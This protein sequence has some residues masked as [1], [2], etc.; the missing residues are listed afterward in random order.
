M[1]PAEMRR[2]RAFK[3]VVVRDVLIC[4][5]CKMPQASL[6][7]CHV[8]NGQTY[9][10]RCHAIFLAEEAKLEGM[11]GRRTYGVCAQCC[12]RGSVWASIRDGDGGC[13]CKVCWLMKWVERNDSTAAQ[14]EIFA[15]KGPCAAALMTPAPSPQGGLNPDGLDSNGV[16]TA[17]NLM[18]T[19]L[20]WQ[21]G[22][23]MGLSE[24]VGTGNKRKAVTEVSHAKRVC[25][26]DTAMECL[27]RLDVVANFPDAVMHAT[28]GD[29]LQEAGR[30]W[31][32]KGGIPWAF[33]EKKLVFGY[34][35]KKCNQN[36]DANEGAKWQ[37]AQRQHTCC[38]FQLLGKVCS[39]RKC[40]FKYHFHQ[41]FRKLIDTESALETHILPDYK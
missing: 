35:G 20:A 12:R 21:H 18:A 17:L 36:G 31:V 2:N 24:T 4:F 10:Q 40:F 26:D 15:D 9:C 1:N 11:R 22:V 14:K 41:T 5:T 25:R 30:A 6:S 7:G 34:R 38:G 3:S 39:G 29:R 28:Y 37:Y 16:A 27:A 32:A 8:A 23:I 33:L 19:E 13:L